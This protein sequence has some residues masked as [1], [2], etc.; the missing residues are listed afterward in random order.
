[1]T[2][3]EKYIVW[4][5]EKKLKRFN[6]SESSFPKAEGVTSYDAM[7]PQ[8]AK[9]Y[10]QAAYWHGTGRF[11]YLPKGK[12]KYE[13]V[14][15]AQ[16]HDVLESIISFGGLMPH[17]DP[18]ILVN[19]VH[20][21]TTSLTSLR[22]YGRLY[23][24]FHQHE[25]MPLGYEYGDAAFW[26]YYLISIAFLSRNLW[27]VLLAAVRMHF[28]PGVRVGAGQWMHTVRKDLAEKPI[29]PLFFYRLRS[30]ISANYGILFAIRGEAVNVVHYNAFIERVEARTTKPILLDHITHLEVPLRNVAETKA[31]LKKHG[32]ML[33]VIPIEYGERWCSTQ[34]LVQL[35]FTEPR[36]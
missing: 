5:A 27:Y 30:D 3:R 4:Y 31:L 22:M 19:G 18:W 7:R 2:L 33:P 6:V 10:E 26:Y 11:Q 12:S 8:I 1:M 9:L 15:H 16:L 32:V 23:A 34:R 24:G 20:Q 14:S 13:G 25:G 29:M 17:Y 21:N 28:S 35:S 36:H